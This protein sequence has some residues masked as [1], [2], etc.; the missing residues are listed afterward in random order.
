M[1]R[2]LQMALLL[3]GS[4]AVCM[5]QAQ[6]QMPQEVH[7]GNPAADEAAH[8]QAKT[9]WIQAN[10]E[11]YRKLGG[12]PEAVVPKPSR[13]EAPAP[14]EAKTDFRAQQTFALRGL[15]AVAL[16]ETQLD[17]AEIDRESAEVQREFPLG[18]TLLQWDAS[19]QLRISDGARLDLRG[20]E[21]RQGQ[22]VQWH[23]PS[24]DCPSCAKTLH[25]LLE[26]E[27]PTARTY[28]LQSED[29]HAQFAYRLH[30]VIQP[31]Q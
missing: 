25:L 20:Q 3:N 31:A 21:S 6:A 26:S 16:P 4:V 28:L 22:Q 11:A 17:Q 7:T 24:P 27:S 2:Y 30:F 23:F 15:A 10:P 5:P 1:K 29:A 19:R 8:V 9:A 12:D 13:P 18:K 14:T